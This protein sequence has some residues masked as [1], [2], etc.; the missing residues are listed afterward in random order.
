MGNRSESLEFGTIRLIFFATLKNWLFF[1]QKFGK[2][3][4]AWAWVQVLACN[5]HL[6]VLV[7]FLN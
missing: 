5:V 2:S 3:K 1:G 4:L 7:E 6:S